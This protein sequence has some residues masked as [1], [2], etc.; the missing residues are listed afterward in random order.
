MN[1][2]S[3][4]LKALQA[5]EQFAIQSLSIADSNSENVMQLFRSLSAGE[6]WSR[7]EPLQSL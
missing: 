1:E 2:A 6:G 5:Q 3:T 7:T 4:K